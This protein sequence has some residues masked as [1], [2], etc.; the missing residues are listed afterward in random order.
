MKGAIF[1]RNRLID[2]EFQSFGIGSGFDRNIPMIH[3]LGFIR[4]RRGCQIVTDV[5]KFETVDVL[6]PALN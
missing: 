1:G 6:I 4:R 5:S 3:P 2:D